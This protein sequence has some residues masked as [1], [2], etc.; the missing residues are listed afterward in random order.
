MGN[1]VYVLVDFTK[2][3]VIPAL[4]GIV[5]SFIGMAIASAIGIL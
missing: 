4:L 3:Y 5:G 1:F 2:R